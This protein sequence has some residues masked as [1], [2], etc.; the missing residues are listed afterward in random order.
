MSLRIKVVVDKFV[1]VLKEVLDAD[2][3]DR[4]MKE[5]EMQSY[6]EEREREVAEREAAWKAELSRREA[7]IAQQEARLKI[8]RE[9]LE[10]EKSVLMGTASNQDNQD[11]A[12]E[13]TVS[14]EKYCYLRFSKAKE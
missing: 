1:K 5:R 4:I 2:I 3:Q 12:L 13:I 11:S 6:I 10:K 9:N 7:E 8:E 14:R